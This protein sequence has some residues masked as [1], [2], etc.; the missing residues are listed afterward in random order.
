M[1]LQAGYQ[2]QAATSPLYKQRCLE[3]QPLDVIDA[4]LNSDATARRIMAKGSQP[5]AGDLI[6]VRLNLNIHRKTGVAVHS[7]HRGGVQGGHRVGRGFWGG[8]V[9][10]YQECVVLRDVYFSVHQPGREMIAG[11]Q[12]SKFPMASIDGELVRFSAPHTFDGIE[13]GFNPRHQHLFTDS[14]GFAVAHC[15]EV[16]VFAHRAYARNMVNYHQAATV[17]ARAGDNP[18]RV[19]LKD[20]CFFAMVA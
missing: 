18:S 6:G 2:I 1:D 17:P 9:L 20:S 4:A 10:T 11:G 13:V 12:S 3:L 19:L 7:I 5:Q 15:E 8:E 16:T 14:E